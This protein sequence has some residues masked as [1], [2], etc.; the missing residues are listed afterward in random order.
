VLPPNATGEVSRAIRRFAIVAAAGEIAT[1]HKL[2]G[3]KV[4]ECF[5]AAEKC[6]TA[7]MEYRRMFDPVAKAVDRVRRFILDNEERFEVV[8]GDA[9]TEKVGYKKKGSYL[10]FPEVFRDEVCA[11]T[12]PDDIARCL[13]NARYLNTSGKN[14]LTKQERISGELAYYYSVSDKILEAE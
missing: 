1:A 12:K 6:F 2:T 4:G 5:A 11:G 13:E 9:L 8:G 3:W 14:R 7:W 10:I